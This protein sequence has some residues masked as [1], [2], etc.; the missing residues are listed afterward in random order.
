[1]LVD[2]MM[3]CSPRQPQTMHWTRFRPTVVM[4]LSHWEGTSRCDVGQCTAGAWVEGAQYQ[5]Q[6]GQ[7]GSLL[8]NAPASGGGRVHSP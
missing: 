8:D 5:G 2:M 7:R 4:R 6:L 3:I 1:M